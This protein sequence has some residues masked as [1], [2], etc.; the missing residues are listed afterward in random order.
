MR[1]RKC[2]SQ[3]CR[4]AFSVGVS[5]PS[6][7]R[8]SRGRIAKPRTRSARAAP[9]LTSATT[10]REHAAHVRAGATGRPD[11]AHVGPQ[12]GDQV[13]PPVPDH[14]RLRD[15]GGGPEG[16]LHTLRR[17]VLPVGG[18]DDVL[19]AVRD[20]QEAVAVEEPDVAGAEPALVVEDLPR[21]GLVQVVA[22]EHVLAPDQDLP[23]R[24]DPHLDPGQGRTDRAHPVTVRPVDGRHGR[25]LGEAVPLEDRDAQRLEQ[26]RHLR[27]ELRPARHR[28]PQP[29]AEPAPDAREHQPIG[30]AQ[31]EGEPRAEP[32]PLPP[33]ARGLPPGAQRGAHQPAPRAP[34]RARG[35]AA[36]P[37][38]SSRRPSAR[39]EGA[40]GAPHRSATP[41]REASGQKATVIPMAAARNGTRRAKTCARGRWSRA[42]SPGRASPRT[43]RVMSTIA[44]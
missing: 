28:V 21:L 17:H 30:Q 24:G 11:P 40:S 31:P 5:S 35:R 39:W 36:R 34:A 25:A 1:S 26:L 23:V 37:R 42:T 2:S 29:A 14:E 3:T 9:R 4:R 33:T 18:H 38:A 8:S 16:R 13:R 6:S 41:R 44:R 15:P 12:Q 7:A 22:G 19:L 20:R 32:A 10:A 43:P 27:R